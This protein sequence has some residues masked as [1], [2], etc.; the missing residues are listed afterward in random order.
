M[1]PPPTA[2]S[3]PVL[4]AVGPTPT[5]IRSTTS[6]RTPLPLP[7]A[8]SPPPHSASTLC[9]T[10]LRHRSAPPPPPGAGPGPPPRLSASSRPAHAGLRARAHSRFHLRD[11]AARQI[12]CVPPSISGVSTF[13]V[14]SPGGSAAHVPRSCAPD[15]GNPRSDAQDRRGFSGFGSLGHAVQRFPHVARRFPGLRIA[16]L[17]LR[18]S[19]R[20]DLRASLIPIPI[21][22]PMPMP[23]PMPSTHPTLNQPCRISVTEPKCWTSR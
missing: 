8:G 17:E 4:T 5:A 14:H 15:P 19:F 13:A 11:A 1:P 20:L 9:A 23:I 2:G 22:I 21:P 10:A 6:T 18:T 7:A 16:F 3:P 12:L